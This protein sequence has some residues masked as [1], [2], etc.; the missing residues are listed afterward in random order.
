MVRRLLKRDIPGL[1]LHVWLAIMLSGMVIATGQTLNKQDFG[2]IQSKPTLHILTQRVLAKQPIGLT[3]LV[4][5]P[6]DGKINIYDR[7]Y[8]PVSLATAR[9][10]IRGMDTVARLRITLPTGTHHLYAV[11]TD[12]NGPSG[13]SETP[14][15]ICVSDVVRVDVVP[16]GRDTHY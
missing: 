15:A 8:G 12:G 16:D 10:L 3:V 9:L 14:A 11:L 1:R 13:C 5:L 2:M 6:I 4:D 7:D